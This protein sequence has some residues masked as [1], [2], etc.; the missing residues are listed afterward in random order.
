MQ[1]I[2]CSVVTELVILFQSQPNYCFGYGD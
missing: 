1:H 2:E